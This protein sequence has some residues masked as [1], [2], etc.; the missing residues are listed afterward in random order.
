MS[1]KLYVAH[2]DEVVTTIQA[3]DIGEEVQLDQYEVEK[4]PDGGYGWVVV[5]SVFL[6]NS[7]VWGVAASYG[8]LL[9]FYLSNNVFPGATALDYAF[10]GGINFGV[11]M[12]AASPV[13]IIVRRF[14]THAPMVAG[15]I[16]QSGG[17][18][19]ASFATQI[20]HL[21]LSQGIL[22]GMGMGLLFIPSVQCTSQW[23][24]KKRSLANGIN[25][26]GSG[27]GGLIFSFATGATIQHVS[28]RWALRVIGIVSGAMN[29]IAT[30][31]IRNRNHVIKPA[32]RGFD[33]RLLGRVQV[34]LLLSW[35]FL[36]MLGYMTVLY[37]LSAF[38]KSI[39]LTTSQSSAIT[40]I[41]NLGTAVGRPFVGILSDR[42]GRMEVAAWSTFICGVSIFALWLPA[43]GFALT[44]VFAIISGAFIGTF[45]MTI[46][47]LCV[48]VVGLKE[49]PSMLSL[50]WAT[51]VLPTTFGE[52]VALQIRR[53]ASDREYLYVQI[54]SGVSY[55]LASLALG[56]LLYLR[57]RQQSANAPAA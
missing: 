51:V 21:Y 20:W 14:G 24:D 41:L 31:L 28:F 52:V 13:T 34:L 38:G 5:F 18:I 32:M 55:L 1:E 11:S 40:A 39:G 23:F 33:W 19:S 2:P 54:Y 37:S 30:L 10:I 15:I 3:D 36:S 50:S 57:R 9:S 48:E 25:S 56:W 26:A 6:I 42:Y 17:Y 44:I 53:T 49:L 7:F 47:P 45:W 8:V 27:I 43:T 46:S 12:L 29:L 35:G 4:P 22:V 16:C